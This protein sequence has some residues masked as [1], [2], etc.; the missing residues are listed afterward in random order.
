MNFY[1]NLPQI[2]NPIFLHIGS[3]KI[4]WY[5]I[6]WIISFL[7]I[8]KLLTYRIKKDKKNI[9][10]INELNDLIFYALFGAII[11][12]RLGY[13]LFYNLNYFILNP[14]EIISPYNFNTDTWTGI[15]GM[16]Y[17][18]G[19]LGVLFVIFWYAHKINKSGFKVISYVIPAIPLGYFFGRIGNFLNNELYGRMTDSWIGMNFTGKDFRHP[20]QLYEAFGEGVILFIILWSLRNNN[21]IE[22]YLLSLYIMGYS[23]VRFVIE[24]FREPDSHIGLLFLNLSMGQILSICMFTIGF[25]IFLISYKRKI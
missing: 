15:Y 18:G 11:G 19:A 25:V 8:Y 24:Y 21:K 9:L 3:F 13:V 23:M 4:Y 1:Q 10:T 20:S 12:G 17:H 7:I 14:L 16:S 5:S 22:K 6:M 2:I